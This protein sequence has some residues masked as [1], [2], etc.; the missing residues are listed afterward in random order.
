VINGAAANAWRYD[1]DDATPRVDFNVAASFAS[2]ASRELVRP[3]GRDSLQACR[4]RSLLPL[5]TTTSCT[6]R[7]TH[8]ASICDIADPS[9]PHG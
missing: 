3:V 2:V 5:R 9:D 7:C 8:A 6:H 1:T 4:S